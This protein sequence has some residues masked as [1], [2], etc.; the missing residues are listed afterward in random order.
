MTPY[1]PTNNKFSPESFGGKRILTRV[2]HEEN[3]FSPWL[4]HVKYRDKTPQCL[5]GKYLQLF[6]KSLKIFSAMVGPIPFRQVK[7]FPFHYLLEG[8]YERRIV[9][10]SVGEVSASPQ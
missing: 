7:P 9:S 2:S 8:F 3:S 5:F 6:R 1:W 4:S 10:G